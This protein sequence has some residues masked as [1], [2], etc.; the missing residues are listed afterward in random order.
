MVKKKIYNVLP[1]K[2]TNFKKVCV[3][4]T[5]LGMII[6][7]LVLTGIGK[8]VFAQGQSNKLQ[9]LQ[10]LLQEGKVEEKISLTKEEADNRRIFYIL[11]NTKIY[12]IQLFIVG[13]NFGNCTGVLL[14]NDIDGA[15]ILTAKH[16]VAFGE[17]IYA[18]NILVKSIVVSPSNDLALLKTDKY[19]INKLPSKLAIKNARITE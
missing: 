6:L 16:C 1:D 18:E 2:T 5:I 14:K 19:I 9:I 7:I 15:D 11:R 3:A 10:K 4:L 17:Q 13:N 12:E 8:S